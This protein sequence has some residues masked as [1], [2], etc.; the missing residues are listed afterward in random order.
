MGRAN[1]SGEIRDFDHVAVHDFEGKFAY[2]GGKDKDD[3]FTISSS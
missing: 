1:L 2:D 3:L